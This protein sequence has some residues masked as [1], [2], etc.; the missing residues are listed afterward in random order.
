MDASKLTEAQVSEAASL[1]SHLAALVTN[2]KGVAFGEVALALE[3]IVE[4]YNTLGMA[5]AKEPYNPEWVQIDL[6][7]VA[8]TL[9]RWGE[10]DP[11]VKLLAEYV[12][13]EAVRALV[14]ESSG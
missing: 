4:V 8:S 11:I 13:F 7:S 3:K 10:Q 6:V 1:L 12:P 2:S 9:T 14:E 5:V